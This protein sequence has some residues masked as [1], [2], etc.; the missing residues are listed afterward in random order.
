MEKN[1]QISLN[2]VTFLTFSKTLNQKWMTTARIFQLLLL[3]RKSYFQ[4]VFHKA[5][6]ISILKADEY[7]LNNFIDVLK[8]FYYILKLKNLLYSV[9]VRN[10]G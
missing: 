9:I 2:D 1:R 7:I 3:T 6:I 10:H 5:L 4:K 8:G